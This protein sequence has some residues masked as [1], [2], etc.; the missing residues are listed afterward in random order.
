MLARDGKVIQLNGKRTK[1]SLV[2]KGK[3]KGKWKGPYK[4]LKKISEHAYRIEGRNGKPVTVNEETTKT[5]ILF[6]T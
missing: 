5:I 2:K 3:L 6:H 1:S 4:V